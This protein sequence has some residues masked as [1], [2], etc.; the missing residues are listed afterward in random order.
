MPFS[1]RSRGAVVALVSLG[2]LA[3]PAPGALAQPA[4]DTLF[5]SQ[6]NPGYDV[7]DYGVR[8]HYA[9]G[10]NR[11]EAVT[12]IR[13]RADHELTAFH[14]DLVGLKVG[15]IRVDGKPA[16]WT[17]H[18]H[19]LVVRP[20]HAVDGGFTTVVEYAGVPREH[21]DPDGS[22]EGWVRTPDGAVALGEPVGAMTWLPSDNTPG[23]KAR[24]TFKV[25]VPSG[26]QVV[27]NGDLASRVRRGSDTTWTWRVED[28]MSTYLATIAIGKFNVYTEHTRSITGRRISL[29]S[30]A[31]PTTDSSASIRAMLPDVIR[32]EEK[33]FGPYPFTSAGVIIDDAQ[34][35][36]ALETQSRPFFPFGTSAA[37]VVHEMAHQWYGD[38]VTLRDWHDIWLA[39]GF[40][41]YAEWLWG[42]AHGEAS[43]AERFDD[44]YAT[45]AGN[46]LWSPAPTEFEDPADLFGSPGYDRGAMTLQALRERVGST[47]FFAILKAWAKEHRQGNA[48]TA[49][50]VALA[51]RI[52]G[53]DLG[54]LFADWLELDGRPTGY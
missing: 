51:E 40:A 17:R 1:I 39:E 27:A 2:L 45:P 31:D 20:K 11:I 52:S 42:A 6:G 46:D 8:L 22:T 53:E 19:E 23:D 28:R 16:T 29:W 30:F 7:R 32:F 44:L 15:A 47:D 26:V 36:Y 14:L 37:T 21:T 34:V 24:F 9:P 25:T 35:G 41:T 49:Q 54:T 43:P 48:R 3:V 33:L 10:T 4:P 38:S 50:F 12:T 5:P 13:A 18:G